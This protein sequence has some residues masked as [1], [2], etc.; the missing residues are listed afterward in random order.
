MLEKT[1]KNT[2]IVRGTNGKF[3]KLP[4][5]NRR[6]ILQCSGKYEAKYLGL[7]GE[8]RKKFEILVD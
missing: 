7:D 4:H 1:Q 6:C 8:G 2:T 5:A 3:S